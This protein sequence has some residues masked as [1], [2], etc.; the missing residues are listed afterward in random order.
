V[1]RPRRAYKLFQNAMP[2][3]YGAWGSEKVAACKRS[4]YVFISQKVPFLAQKPPLVE[5]KNSRLNISLYL[6][7]VIL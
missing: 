4:D 1:Q 2:A 5:K 6:P 3:F 7:F